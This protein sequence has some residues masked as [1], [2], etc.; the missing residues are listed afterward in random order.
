MTQQI[1]VIT[2][3]GPSGVGKGTVCALLAKHL[4]WHYLDSGALYRLTALAC[5][6]K[7]VSLT[8]EDQISHIAENLII[9]FLPNEGILLYDVEVEALIRTEVAGNNASKVASLEKVRAALLKRQKSFLQMPGLIADGRDMGTTI[10][11]Q[12]SLKIFLS[13]SAEERA[14]RRYKQLI[15]KGNDVKIADLVN[16]IRERDERDSSRSASPLIAAQDAHIIDTSELSIDSVF[17]KVV[18]LY[19]Q[20]LSSAL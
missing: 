11:P 5:A 9:Q 15:E 2:V 4:S 16:E 20:S 12:A 8:D 6:Q 14:K 18:Q 7:N 19:T 3:D 17:E 1:P 13:A 10:F